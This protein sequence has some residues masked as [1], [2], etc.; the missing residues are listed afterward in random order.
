M[1]RTILSVS[2][3][4]FSL[5]LPVYGQQSTR[6]D[7]EEF[8]G[9]M[10]GRYVCD[11]IWIADW[12]GVGGKEGDKVTGHANLEVAADGNVL[13]GTF[14]G[15]NVTNTWITVY[16]AA[17]KQI[18]FLTGSSGGTIWNG[19]IFKKNGNWVEVGTGGNPDG[20]KIEFNNTLT[21]SDNGRTHH[22][23]GESSIGGSPA[24]SLEDVC[25][26]VSK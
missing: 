25:H 9:V 11:I 18:R 22:W 8:L 3:L 19:I 4:V 20:S 7:F 2:L 15:G 21:L 26:R 24:R 6:A 23:S 1:F 13:R 17:A 10:E 16:D 12:P 5:A 14:Y